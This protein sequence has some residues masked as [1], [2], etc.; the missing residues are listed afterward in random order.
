[1]LVACTVAVLLA[2]GAL[3]EALTRNAAKPGVPP[4]PRDRGRLVLLDRETA[5]ALALATIELPRMPPSAGPVAVPIAADPPAR[6][7]DA[8]PSTG[9]GDEP[10]PPPPGP[11]EPIYRSPAEL[12]GPVRPR[13]APDM[14][15]L[16]GLPWSG[17]P[18]RLRLFIDSQGTVV[19]ARALASREADEVVARLCQ[20]FLATGFTPGRVNGEPVPSYKDIEIAIDTLH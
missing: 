7:V 9:A 4:P 19:D 1:M 8:A 6:G 15:M 18:T 2:H 14:A 17:L 11:R 13:S 16:E 20:M 3:I 10:S 12:D 5:A